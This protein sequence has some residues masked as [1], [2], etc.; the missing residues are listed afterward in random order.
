MIKGTDLET[1]LET[2]VDRHGLT[3]VL[4]C[5][6]GVC[7]LKAAHIRENWAAT[8]SEGL[9]RSWDKAAGAIESAWTKVRELGL[10]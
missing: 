8:N 3:E 6:Q 2:L 10:S 9:A 7:G 4:N 1:E 5:I